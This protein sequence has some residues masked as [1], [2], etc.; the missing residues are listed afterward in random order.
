M[1]VIWCDPPPLRNTK[2]RRILTPVTEHP[3]AWALVR[4]YDSE[5]QATGAVRDLRRGQ[6]VAPEGRWQFRRAWI[7]DTRG[8]G[9]WAKYLGAEIRQV[10]D[11]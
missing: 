5:R 9:V 10:G 11:L 2:W 4:E 6:A 7:E 8:W 1:T 3:G